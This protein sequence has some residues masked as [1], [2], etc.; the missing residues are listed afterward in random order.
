ML[1]VASDYDRTLA[2]EKNGFV[3]SDEVK[4]KVNEFSRKYP[5]VVVTGRERKFI[6]VLAKG[7]NPTAWVLENGPLLLIGEKEIYLVDEEWFEIRKKITEKLEKLGLRYSLGKIIIYLDNAVN[8]ADKLNFDYARVEWNRND[9]MIMPKNMD[10][11]KGLLELVK[12]LNFKGKIIA[13]GD[14]ENDIPLF[15]VADYKVAVAN[16]LDE[17]K[18]LAD[19]V[20][21][22]EN[23]KGVISLLE[24]IE[25]GDLFE[26]I[27]I[28]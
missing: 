6:N 3:I 11:G 26:K 8:F 14:S 23:G 1:L 22:E 12:I 20:L 18:R 21:D 17:V 2:S 25:S 15:K 13:V 19:L 9:A 5:F 16:A 4:E 27:N 24:M 28:N 7:L 10:K